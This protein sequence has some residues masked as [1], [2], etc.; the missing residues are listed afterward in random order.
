[1]KFSLIVATLHR[2]SE[3][4]S[5]L[6]SLVN[7]VYN[8]FE[9]IIVDQNSDD[10]LDTIIKSYS[11]TLKVTHTHCESK[12]ASHAR[13]HGIELATGEIITFPDD[14]CEYPHDLL[15]EIYKEFNNVKIS[16]IS[17]SSHDKNGGKGIARFAKE[18][19][20]ITKLNIYMTCVESGIFIRNKCLGNVRF[21]EELG[22]GSPTMLWSDEGP[23]LLLSLIKKGEKFLFIPELFFY[24]PNPVK[25]YDEKSIIRSY[26]YGCGR[27]AYL[28]KRNYPL[29]FVFYVWLLYVAGVLIALFQL[30]PNKVKY[31]YHGLVGRV[32]GYFFQKKFK[33]TT[34]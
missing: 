2:T 32:A 7:Q 18:R 25:S 17:V 31:Y 34:L 22:I 12:G 21:D 33:N 20:I 27:G 6:T 28:R 13:N 26:R 16:G 29:W 24:H 30:N 19:K 3:V 14:D 11:K 5:L 23:D 9:V 1:M 8:D 15:S 4:D 10:R